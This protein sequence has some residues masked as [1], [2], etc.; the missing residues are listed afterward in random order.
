MIL[1]SGVG[2]MSEGFFKKE[3]VNL[4]QPLIQTDTGY[5]TQHLNANCL[6][7]L[8]KM[9]WAGIGVDSIVDI[10]KTFKKYKDGF[11]QGNF[12]EKLLLLPKE[13]C[14]SHIEDFCNTMQTVDHTGWVCGLGHG[15]TKTTPEE[16]VKMFVDMIRERFK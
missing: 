16:N 11:I 7:T 15:I 12:D 3:Y 6:P 8:Y 10:T 1:D 9:G 14:R 13:E 4:L 5:Y 2:N